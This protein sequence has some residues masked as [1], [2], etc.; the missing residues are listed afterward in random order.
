MNY[1]FEIGSRF[2][3]IYIFAREQTATNTFEKKSITKNDQLSN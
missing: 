2:L 1:T 3:L